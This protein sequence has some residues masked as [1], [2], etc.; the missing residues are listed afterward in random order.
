MARFQQND[1]YQNVWVAEVT[2]NTSN[3][4][5][6]N[7]TSFDTANCNA[8][9]INVNVTSLGVGKKIKFKLQDSDDNTT[10]ADVP[11]GVATD[12]VQA[13]EITANG[14]YSYYYAGDKRYV[15][16]VVVSASASPAAK[17]LC[18]YQRHRLHN[19]PNNESFSS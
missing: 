2:A 10:F 7:V 9:T 8:P 14:G 3:N 19:L 16:L 18:L 13:T 5:V 12:V 1:R 6:T 4:G 15:R 11:D 17:V